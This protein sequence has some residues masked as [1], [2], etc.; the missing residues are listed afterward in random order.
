M[1]EEEKGL[2]EFPSGSQTERE[3]LLNEFRYNVLT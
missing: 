2:H 1:D 3:I